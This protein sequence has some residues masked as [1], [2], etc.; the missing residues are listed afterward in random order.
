MVRALRRDGGNGAPAR[1]IG[2]LRDILLFLHAD[3]VR[4]MVARPC[5]TV[6]VQQG[7]IR[8]GLEL[9]TTLATSL[10]G[11]SVKNWLASLPDQIEK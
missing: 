8:K 1:I 9:V 7:V 6:M 10:D 5:L 2:E 4:A 3:K 11:D